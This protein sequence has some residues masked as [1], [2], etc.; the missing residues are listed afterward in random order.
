MML[1]RKRSATVHEPVR[2]CLQR[3]SDSASTCRVGLVGWQRGVREFGRCGDG[4]SRNASELRG[5]LG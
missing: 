2:R 1:P 4:V 5:R 3:V